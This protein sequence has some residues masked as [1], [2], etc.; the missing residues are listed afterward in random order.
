[1]TGKN[2]IDLLNRRVFINSQS[3]NTGYIHFVSGVVF[4]S[5]GHKTKL[6]QQHSLQ[7]ILNL[8]EDS[9]VSTNGKDKRHASVRSG[10]EIKIYSRPAPRTW[11]S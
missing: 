5:E 3:T 1:M 9:D 4:N 10:T 2:T 7:R 6:R 8:A 11:F